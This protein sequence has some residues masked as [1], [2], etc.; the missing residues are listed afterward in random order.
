MLR[1]LRLTDLRVERAGRAVIDGLTLELDSG[2]ALL[3][4][5]PNG[6][7]KT[8]LLRTL[9]GLL[10]PASGS[11]EFEG[12]DPDRDVRE[13]SH[14]ISLADA[15]KASLSVAENAGFWSGYL[16]TGVD[17]SAALERLGLAALAGVPAG[18]LSSGQRRRLGLARLLVVARQV[19]LL[20]EPTVAL[21]AG[22]V[23]ILTEI[24]NEHLATGGLA[25]VATHTALD[26]Q[27][28]RTL[29][30]DAAVEP[31]HTAEFGR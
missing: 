8:T 18:W 29:R 4:T 21:D 30:L 22:A 20:D 9:A 17:P 23:S 27:S 13:A 12:W 15:V 11:F 16:G 28:S 31:R 3:V 14:F 24:I 10:P 25:V 2:S 5:G 26:L 7:G 19:W 1:R 6:A